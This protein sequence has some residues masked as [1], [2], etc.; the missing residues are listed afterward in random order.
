[1]DG[2][3]IE[4]LRSL[5]GA[6]GV[7]EPPELAQRSAGLRR[8]DTLQAGL[9]VRPRHTKEVAAVLRICQRAGWPVVPQ[10]GLT[11]LV[12]GADAAPNEVILSLERMRRIETIDPVSRTVI[13]Q[14]GAT[15][16]ALEEEVERHGL[17]FPLDLGARGSCT[18]GGNLATNAGGNRVI[19]YGM[20]RHMVLGVEAVLADG[21]VIDGLSRLIKNNVGYD[22]KQLFIGSEGT[23][24]IITRAA[25]RLWEKPPREDVALAAVSSF[26]AL[27]LL[28]RHMEGRLGGSLS[29]FEVMWPEFYELVTSPPARSRPPLARGQAHYVLIEA[30]GGDAAAPDAGLGRAMEEALERRLI[31]DAVVARSDAERQALWAIR[32]DTGQTRRFEP[33]SVFDVS[34]PI[35]AMAAYVDGVRRALS[36][37][38]PAARCFVF[39][40][41]GDSNL[42]LVTAVGD[43]SVVARAAI[44][45]LIYAPLAA[46]GGS[47]SA[48]HG[49]GLDKKGHLAL[50]RS[51]EEIALMRRLKYALDPRALLNPGK[52]ID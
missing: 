32:N 6:D 7:L 47:I 3:A 19:R 15:L 46:V 40:H 9:L 44:E 17:M 38:W 2:H 41:M 39:G 35:S 18:I 29:A 49:I 45:H 33:L 48:E 51:H 12:R 43:D 24:G 25:L 26:D 50:T 42:H 8:R 16:Q 31:T 22:I 37:R 27:P 4:E 10:G 23:L 34:L 28:L 11:G 52:I 14:A 30:Q 1:L 20:M 36:D 21:T 5:L 13:V